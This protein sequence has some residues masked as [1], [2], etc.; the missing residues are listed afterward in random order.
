[1]Y[2]A[3]SQTRVSVTPTVS[4]PV[5]GRERGR[6]E[7]GGAER[8]LRGECIPP[9]PF[10]CDPSSVSASARL[11][12]EPGL[13][14][15]ALHEEEEDDKAQQSQNSDGARRFSRPRARG[16]ELD[17]NREGDLPRYGQ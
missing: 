1:M 15:V 14:A 10:R 4:P 12:E 13:G 6:R 9:R 17:R 2:G 11:L 16:E 5:G 8:A 3:C 7:G